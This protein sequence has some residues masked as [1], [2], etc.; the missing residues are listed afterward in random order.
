M[1]GPGQ[2]EDDEVEV[3]VVLSVCNEFDLYTVI[4]SDRRGKVQYRFVGP[5]GQIGFRAEDRE[6]RGGVAGTSTGEKTDL[7]NV[8]EDGAKGPRFEWKTLGD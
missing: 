3:L 2:R 5:S 7:S 6:R 1:T 4:E 8:R